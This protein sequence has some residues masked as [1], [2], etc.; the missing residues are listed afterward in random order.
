[1]ILSWHGS[2]LNDGI[3]GYPEIKQTVLWIFQ[4]RCE[5]QTDTYIFEK[6]KQVIFFLF[7]Q[8]RYFKDWSI[9]ISSLTLNLSTVCP[10]IGGES[11]SLWTKWRI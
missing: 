10:Y 2:D 8:T 3:E 6:L 7:M 9:T 4:I 1:M 11:S 5:T